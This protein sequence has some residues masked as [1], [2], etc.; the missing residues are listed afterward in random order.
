[1]ARQQAWGGIVDRVKKKFSKW[2]IKMLFIRGRLTLVKS[3]LGSLPIYNF[4]IFKVPKC[5]LNEL[6]GIR[7][8]FFN[9]HVQ[10]KEYQEKDKIESKPDKNG[11]RG[12][13]RKIFKQLQ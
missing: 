6:E 10:V 8:K 5:V 2:K 4:S 13:A 9:G 7:K 3:I 1:M 12:E 11:K